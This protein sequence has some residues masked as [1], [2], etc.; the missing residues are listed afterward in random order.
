MELKTV[1]SQLLCEFEPKRLLKDLA[2]ACSLS[3]EMAL[4]LE[5]RGAKPKSLLP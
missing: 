5:M 3:L 2:W 4:L 1:R